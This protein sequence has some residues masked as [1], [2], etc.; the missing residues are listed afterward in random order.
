MDIKESVLRSLEKVSNNLGFSIN[1]I[2]VEIPSDFTHGDLTSNIAMQVA[3]SVGRNPMDIANEILSAFPKDENIEKVEVI[4]P[5]F[6][7][8][9]FS[10]KYL[11]SVL[12]DVNSNTEYFKLDVLTGKKYIIEYTDPNPF[13]IFHIGHLYTNIVGESFARLVEALGASVVRANYQG[14][15]GLHV[16][17]TIWGLLKM[18]ERDSISFE[19]LKERDLVDRVRYLGDAYMLGFNMYD[20]EKDKIAIKEIKELNYYIFSLHIPSLERKEYFNKYEQLNI[21][22]MY[23]EERDW[24]LEYFERIYARTGTKFDNYFLESEMGQKGL[25]IVKE[26]IVGKGKGIFKESEGSVI[27][28]GDPNKGL[29]T[30]VF[31]NSEG[32]PTYE[33]KELALAFKK[34]EDIHFDHSVIITANEQTPYFKVVFDALSQLSPEIASKY[35]HFD[36]GMVKLPNAEKMSSRKGKIIEGEWLLNETKT[37]VE[38]SMLESG[39]WDGQDI[40]QVSDTIGLS[41]IKYSFL[42]VSVGKDVVFD[43]SKATSFDGDTGPYL[44]YVYARC[45]SIL[46]EA[47]DLKVDFGNKE[48]D[49]YSKELLRSISKY[50]SMLL[51]SAL[52]YSPNTLCTYLFDLGKTFNTFYQNVKVLESDNSAF[53][54]SLVSVTSKVMKHGL[55]VLGINIVERM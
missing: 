42:K 55:N 36:H 24:C 22:D 28:K 1:E 25:D 8:F 18:F 10:Q 47:G 51:S 19:E 4:K 27:Y 52:S 7:N 41:A 20:D 29:H 40:S 35:L 54:L 21:K 11:L 37:T 30:R 48:L 5:G 33:A 32:L 43:F 23:F 39:R 34:Y 31:I 46:S 9:F 15:V 14:D 49:V 6:I 26:N 38:K 3:K 12:N 2:K 17:K 44:L 45:N 53:L 13:K 50:K 16:A